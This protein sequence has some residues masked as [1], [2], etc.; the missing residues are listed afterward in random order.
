MTTVCGAVQGC[1]GPRHGQDHGRGAGSG[2]A[3][4][5]PDAR[6]LGLADQ[7]DVDSCVIENYDYS[8]AE[9]DQLTRAQHQ[10]LW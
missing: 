1:G 3:P 7:Q 10:K 9:Y 6:R 8:K 2:L 4:R 5:D